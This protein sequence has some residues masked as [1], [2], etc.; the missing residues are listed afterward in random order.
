M[1]RYVNLNMDGSFPG[2]RELVDSLCLFPIGMIVNWCPHLMAVLLYYCGAL[3]IHSSDKLNIFNMLTILATQNGTFMALI[4]FFKSKE[5]IFS[6]AAKGSNA[7]T[8]NTAANNKSDS[9]VRSLHSYFNSSDGTAG[10][11]KAHGFDSWFWVVRT[12]WNHF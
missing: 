4:F 10:D 2:V 3:E 12:A 11:V 5:A 7:A 8:N 6:L 9:R 1:F